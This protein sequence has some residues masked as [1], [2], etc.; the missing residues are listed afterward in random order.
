MAVNVTLDGQDG[1][2]VLAENVIVRSLFLPKG[3]K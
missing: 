3:Q 1:Q 2:R